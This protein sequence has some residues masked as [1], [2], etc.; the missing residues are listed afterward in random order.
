MSHHFYSAQTDFY[1]NMKY[2]V[3]TG[4]DGWPWS[5]RRMGVYHKY[6][7]GHRSSAWIILQPTAAAT[8]LPALIAAIPTLSTAALHGFLFHS[9]MRSWRGFLKEQESKA[10]E[11]VCLL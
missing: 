6:F 1:Y 4:R 3:K 8:K 11:A 7:L 10:R 5:F 2:L 9:I